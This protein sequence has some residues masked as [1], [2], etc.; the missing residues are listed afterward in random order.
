MARGKTSA[1]KDHAYDRARGIKEGSKKDI[2]MD[3]KRGIM[4]HGIKPKGKK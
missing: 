2:A 4:E 3:R 1:A